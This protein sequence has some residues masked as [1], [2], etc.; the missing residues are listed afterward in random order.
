MLPAGYAAAFLI[1]LIPPLW[2]RIMNPRVQALRTR[3]QYN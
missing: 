3:Y 2:F 1:V